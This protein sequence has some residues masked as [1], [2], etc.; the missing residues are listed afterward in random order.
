[1]KAELNGH[2]T[3]N[4]E[5][6]KSFLSDHE[7]A[8]FIQADTN[9]LVR[10]SVPDKIIPFIVLADGTVIADVTAR[11]PKTV[12]ENSQSHITPET[13]AQGAGF[14]DVY[15]SNRTLVFRHVESRIFSKKW[16]LQD[17]VSKLHF[18]LELY[19]PGYQVR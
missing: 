13:P 6:H 2:P 12:I 11:N 5:R 1:M 16:H 7:V 15:Y 19:Y 18:E 17:V 14:I 3:I 9:R 4:G 8:K 10:I